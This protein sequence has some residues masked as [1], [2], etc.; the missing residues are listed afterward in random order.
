MFRV[1]WGAA[2]LLASIAIAGCGGGSKPAESPKEAVLTVA[3]QYFNAL[4]DHDEATVCELLTGKAKRELVAS[5]AL[6]SNGKGSLSCEDTINEVLGLYG[7]DDLVKAEE[8]LEEMGL[9]NVTV[10]G[11]SASVNLPISTE[12]PLSLEEVGGNWYI[13]ETGGESVKLGDSRTKPEI[14]SPA[15]LSEAAVEL[16]H[17]LYWAGEQESAEIEFS[18]PQAARTYVRYLTGGAEAGDPNA[19]FLTI[20]TYEFKDAAKAL[21]EQAKK[22]DGV[23]AAAPGG[24]VVFFNTTHPQSVYLAY[25]GE[26]AQIEV[27]DPNP[28]RSIGLV[29]SGLIVPVG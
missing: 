1:K 21:K 25:P 11:T 5:V 17:P 10:N 29:S 13:S 18:Q 8:G 15:Q 9:D 26:E 12:G 2:I 20:G 27:Y 4:I 19:E 14:V 7:K 16:D 22:P 6:L 23:L 28:K 24:G 3:Q